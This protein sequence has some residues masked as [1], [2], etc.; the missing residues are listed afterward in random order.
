MRRI[1]HTRVKLI[2]V[3]TPHPVG[4]DGQAGGSDP[5]L[6]LHEPLPSE[7]TRHEVIQAEP[8]PGEALDEA[9][10]RG[11]A[12][13]QRRAEAEFQAALEGVRA[14]EDQ[15]I[16]ALTGGISEQM[17]SLQGR[18]E[19]DAYKFALAVAERIIR[20]EILLTDD[21]VIAQIK[22][23]MQRIV[24][25]ESIK[26]RVHPTDE[27]VVSAHRATFL[28]SLGNL[29]DLV[30]EADESMERGGCIIESASGN[31]DARIST[32]LRQIETALFG[33]GHA[34]AEPVP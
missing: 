12:E 4:G 16:A 32:Q 3:H 28:A 24:G 21:V 26:L 2:R 19:N 33:A 13:G 20:R 1:P 6:P 30:I 17:K 18:V 27:P 10:A 11:L 5:F 9:Y 29:R 7:D 15:R 22:D 14:E 23:A 31:V 25:V 34:E 8:D